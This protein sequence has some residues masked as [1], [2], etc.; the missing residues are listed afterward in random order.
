MN[1][2]LIM[3]GIVYHLSTKLQ[4]GVMQDHLGQDI[5]VKLI[6]FLTQFG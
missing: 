2:Y 3:S 4:K 1:G 5:E 6:E